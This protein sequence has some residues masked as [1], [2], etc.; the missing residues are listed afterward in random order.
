M[1]TITNNAEITVFSTSS[2]LFQFA[3]KDFADRANA[4]VNDKEVFSVVLAGGNTPKLFFDTL[5]MSEYAKNIPWQAIQFFFGDER[6]VPADDTKS[7]YHMAY[8]YLFSR[9]PVNRNNIYRILT[10]F[11]DPKEAA[12]NY[13]QTLRKIFR[14]TD[15]AVPQFDLV[16]LGLGS[17]AHTASL[18]PGSDLVKRY[19]E[20][21]TENNNQ[22]VAAL[23]VPE[24]DM[25]RITLTTTAINNGLNIIFLVTGADKATAVCEV[26][27]G[28]VDPLHYPA[29]LIHGRAKKTLWYLDKPAGKK[30]NNSEV[31]NS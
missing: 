12:K 26:L 31:T 13:E 30:L 10:G 11:T 25:Y 29:Q 19:T 20:N 2:E 7:N 14:L 15:N 17:N 16:Y 5:T 9:V 4:A 1:V 28:Q 8:E 3:A 21:S 22:L 27:E 18:M 23:F 24:L 6:Y